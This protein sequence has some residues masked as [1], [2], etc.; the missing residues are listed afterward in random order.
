MREYTETND[1]NELSGTYRR[2]EFDYEQQEKIQDIPPDLSE[3][4]GEMQ[5]LASELEEEVQDIPPDIK[6]PDYDEMAK[7]VRVDEIEEV[8]TNGDMPGSMLKS[9]GNSD[10]P[11]LMNHDKKPDSLDASGDQDEGNDI[12]DLDEIMN[13]FSK[14]NWEGLSDAERQEAVTE[15][16]EYIGKELDFENPP[17]VE[18]CDLNDPEGIQTYGYYNNETNKI[19]INTAYMDDVEN[20]V[21]TIAHESRHCYQHE[22][23]EN[24]QTEED[25][26]HKYEFENYITA[27]VD[28]EAYENQL[29][30]SDARDYGDY[31]ENM[32][33]ERQ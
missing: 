2:P 9:K 30:E 1:V 5:D 24:P 12:R 13:E 26:Q 11:D 14:E 7:A 21:N 15:L 23:A 33:K 25:Y 19:T 10:M 4:S 6:E 32:L 18:F 16:G 28:F 29:I 3:D 17:E 8:S 31:Y 20:V 22:R 27:E